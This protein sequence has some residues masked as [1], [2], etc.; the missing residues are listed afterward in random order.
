MSYN[1]L[2]IDHLIAQFLSGNATEHERAELEE[3]LAVSADNRAVFEE[4]KKAWQTPPVDE[5]EKR[6]DNIRDRIWEDAVA[7]EEAGEEG[8]G[9]RKIFLFPWR[10]IAAA[11]LLVVAGLYFYSNTLEH[12][13]S[14]VAGKPDVWVEKENPT[15]KRSVYFLPDST[16][17][18]LN[19]EST[20]GFSENFSDTL[21]YVR[22]RGEAFFEVVKDASRPFIVEANGITVQA[23]G[24]A[25][26]VS[27]NLGEPDITVALLEG[28]VKIENKEKT[29]TV[30]LKPGEEL[31]ASK[32]NTVFATQRFNYDAAIG[33]KDG[34]LVLQQ[35]NFSS[36]CRKIEKWYDVK[37][38][39]K[40][41]APDDWQIRAR[42][43]NES[44]RNVLKD[45]S[46]NKDF[47]YKIEDKM[48]Y[49]T[50]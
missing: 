14:R 50:F 15:G 49:L 7:D 33:W 32:G 4:L 27:Q 21:R 8:L 42:Y 28:K 30:I 38:E 29:H 11:F 25:F 39:V 35:D 18:W 5:Y 2:H 37:I 6:M 47:A 20:I 16:K 46:F 19:A 12:N 9:I 1:H 3:W 24:T 40:G 26:N 23:L 34:I 13:K 41:K 22:L 45:L 44:L 31:V 10:S 48:V 36:F 17:V 43:Q